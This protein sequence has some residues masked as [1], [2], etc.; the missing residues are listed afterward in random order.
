MQVTIF[1]M[2]HFPLQV[3]ADLPISVVVT[4]SGESKMSE[5][6]SVTREGFET[7]EDARDDAAGFVKIGGKVI[8]GGPRDSGF[9]WTG[10]IRVDDTQF[11]VDGTFHCGRC[12]G[13]GAF[14]TGSLNGKPVGPGGICF[15]CEGKGRHTRADRKRN[16]FHD[17]NAWNRAAR[18]FA[19]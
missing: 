3:S 18:E 13:T 11:H 14:I 2:P 5:I 4:T 16:H 8:E 19:A 15:R 17:M 9:G 7:I 10:E 1:V 6:K 12:A